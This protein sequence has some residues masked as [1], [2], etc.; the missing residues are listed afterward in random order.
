M[1]ESEYIFSRSFL[2]SLASS[3]P[4]SLQ[5]YEDAHQDITVDGVEVGK[6]RLAQYSGLMVPRTFLAVGYDLND[7]ASPFGAVHF[8]DKQSVG[9]RLA[10]SALA[11][12][13]GQWGSLP[14]GPMAKGMETSV[15]GKGGERARIQPVEG[16]EVVRGGG[17]GG[18]GVAASLAGSTAAGGKAAVLGATLA[19]DA[20]AEAVVVARNATSSFLPFSVLITYE[21]AGSQGLIDSGI[22][23]FE[24]AST[25]DD[26]D[27]EGK[28]VVPSSSTTV[29]GANNEKL[30]V[31][32][33]LP[34]DSPLAEEG[35]TR[36]LRYAFRNR[37]CP[38]T[39]LK[40]PYVG[41]WCGVYST[42]EGLPALPFVQDV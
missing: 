34:L 38:A 9:Q 40:V 17:D 5:G 6:I 42:P 26:I 13:Y 37:P 19:V 14:W 21:G 27:T 12:V 32:F 2:R 33:M 25:I 30:L 23:L 29:M 15:G 36:V 1:R 31:E 16:V 4:P 22:N 41:A 28:S 3:L 10:L 39:V 24:L 18:G 11:N 7:D 35:A 20:G 8:R